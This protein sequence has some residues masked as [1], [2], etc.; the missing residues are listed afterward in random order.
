MA[1][2]PKVVTIT[3]ER[4]GILAAPFTMF[5]RVYNQRR[6][7]K[8]FVRR[9]LKVAYHGTMIGWGWTM[10]EPLALTAVYWIVFSLLRG[11][12]DTLF[13][14]EILLGVLT[15]GMFSRTLSGTTT[16]IVSN[17]G[18]IKQVSISREVFLWAIGGFQTLRFLLSALI[19][20]P[21]LLIMG[22]E[23]TWTLLLVPLVPLGVQSFAMGLGMITSITHTHVRDTSHV[24]SILVTAGFFLS[25]VFFGMR[26]IP[27]EHHDMFAL[28]PVA[29]YIELM[30]AL[31][32]GN[33]DVLEPS[34]VI[35]AVSISVAT[36]ILGCIVFVRN[37]AKAVKHL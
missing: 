29:T 15:Y 8:H 24:V 10:A 11:E 30:R 1:G 35:Q 32:T 12:D 27:G 2:E 21:V 20:P 6:L 22:V 23:L 18:L 14:L 31:V 17:S 37:E 33:W 19:I 16:S 3:G 34:Y 4:P 7:V 28:N 9:D 25:G 36:L 13:V 26:H 5:Q